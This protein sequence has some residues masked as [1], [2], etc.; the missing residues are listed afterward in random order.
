M[1]K[2]ILN[3]I[4]VSSLIS[5]ITWGGNT[6]DIS[7]KL[8][9]KYLYADQDY[10]TPKIYPNL[11]DNIYFY[12]DNFE[13]F[14][15]KI[16]VISNEGKQ[17]TIELTCYDDSIKL[18]RSKG[19]FN[20][21][22]TSAETI[23]EQV[24]NEVGLET[25]KIPRTGILQKSLYSDEGL[26]TII[27]ETW[28]NVTIQN[29]KKYIN[30]MYLGKFYVIETGKD[31]DITLYGEKDIISISYSADATNIINR[32]K[33]YDT[34]NQYIGTVE[35][36]DLINKFGIF[37]NVYTKEEDKTPDIV[38]KE[39]LK[40]IK[41][42]INIECLGNYRLITGYCLNIQVSEKLGRFE[43]TS[44]TH[45]W[46]NG[47]YKTKLELNFIDWGELWAI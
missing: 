32:V 18:S 26:Y 21:K 8:R 37:Q 39:M 6:S 14:R 31:L 28:E 17:V 29:G 34:E 33:I 5:S 40:D 36:G 12:Y 42:S 41:Q 3:K 23:T 24:L 13:I 20:F 19:I 2:V 1:I 27:K 22:N 25:G 16:Y 46:E 44:D 9:I 45:T 30:F 38:A 11:G 15:G 35:E 43:I 7:R 4:D 10:Y 47:G